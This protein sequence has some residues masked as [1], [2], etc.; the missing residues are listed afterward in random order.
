MR[1]ATLVTFRVPAERVVS[2]ICSAA[3]QRCG[4]NLNSAARHTLRCPNDEKP[5]PSNSP[6]Q[7]GQGFSVYLFL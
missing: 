3:V 1:W 2:H 4:V 7:P 5:C 6:P